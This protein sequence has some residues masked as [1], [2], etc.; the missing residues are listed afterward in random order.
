MHACILVAVDVTDP[1]DRAEVEAAVQFQLLPFYDDPDAPYGSGYWDDYEI[2]GRF[3]G[4][5]GEHGDIVQ[6]KT[7]EPEC[8]RPFYAFV[9]SGRWHGAPEEDYVTLSKDALKPETVLVVVDIHN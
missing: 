3:A 8:L 2:G 7:I 4:I 9:E 6:V 1:D 5:L